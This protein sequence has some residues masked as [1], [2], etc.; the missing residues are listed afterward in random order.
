MKASNFQVIYVIWLREMKRFFRAKSRIV[1]T[2]FLPFF[3]LF[4]MSFGFRSAEM[5]GVFRGTDYLNFLVPGIIGMMM[6]F[7]SMFIGLSVL[8]DREFGFLKEIMVAPVKRLTIV[9]G[10]ISGGVTNNL[11]QG[12]LILTISLFLGFRITDIFS[13]LLALIFMILISV[14]F[15]GLGIAVASK[16]EDPQGFSLVM[17]F[18][19]FPSFLLSGALFPI[20]NF[21]DWIKSIILINPL[22]YGVDGLR[23]SLI[24]SSQFPLFLDLLVILIFDLVMVALSSWLFSRTET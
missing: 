5:P 15:V 3:F 16:M 19:T 7:G 23:A 1:S 8:W 4:T 9:L 20:T 21:P 10:R 17:H 13:F 12:I 18:F 22:T 14:G 24:G 2:L 11:F 6:L